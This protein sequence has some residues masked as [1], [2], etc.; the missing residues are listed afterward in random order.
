ML[1]YRG[2]QGCKPCGI[3][4]GPSNCG[5]GFL[6]VPLFYLA[7]YRS[8]NLKPICLLTVGT[9]MG[10]LKSAVPASIVSVQTTKKDDRKLP[11]YVTNC[12]SDLTS[13]CLNQLSN[14]LSNSVRNFQINLP[15]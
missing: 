6:Q 12:L 4:C 11:S 15:T 10:P 8:P 7:R 9:T 13:R 1:T 2:G 14:K 5:K 3:Y